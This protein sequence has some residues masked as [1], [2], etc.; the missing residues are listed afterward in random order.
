VKVA[1]FTVGATMAQSVRWKQAA[2]VDGHRAVG[3]WLAEAADA[4]LRARARAGRPIALAWHR[5]LFL[6]ALESGEVRVKGHISPPF[7]SYL[8][9]AAGPGNTGCKRHTLVH[10]PTRQV[11]A[12]LRTKMQSRALAAELAPT[13]IRDRDLA[14]GVVDRHERESV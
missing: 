13:W 7:G 8:G 6:V 5:G 2:E 3:T 9:T 10:L 14:A 12:T 1:S 11:I 4:Y